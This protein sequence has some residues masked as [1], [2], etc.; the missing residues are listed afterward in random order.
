VRVS[1]DEG[2]TC[3]GPILRDAL[4]AMLL[5]MRPGEATRFTL[6][7][8]VPAKAGTQRNNCQRCMPLLDARVRGHERW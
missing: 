2:G 4:L 8:L 3:G 6:S 1:K 5:R 7:P